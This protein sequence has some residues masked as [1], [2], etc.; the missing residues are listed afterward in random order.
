MILA[1]QPLNAI[2]AEYSIPLVIR[3]FGRKSFAARPERTTHAPPGPRKREK[4]PRPYQSL[5][6][7]YP[8]SRARGGIPKLRRN[9]NLTLH[10]PSGE[11]QDRADDRVGCP[12]TGWR[13]RDTPPITGKS[14]EE[15]VDQGILVE[16]LPAGEWPGVRMARQGRRLRHLLIG[17]EPG[18]GA[19]FYPWRVVVAKRIAGGKSSLS[20]RLHRPVSS[21]GPRVLDGK[22]CRLCHAVRPGCGRQASRRGW[23]R[24]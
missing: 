19:A 15:W 10:A 16:S 5:P 21:H 20:S 6:S 7:P 2:G 14:P 18:G 22:R 13:E 8:R 4:H 12:A 23:R 11:V 17:T 1:R 3:P 9:P 24:A